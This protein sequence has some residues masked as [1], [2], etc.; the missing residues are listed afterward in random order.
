MKVIP[1]VSVLALLAS[2]LAAQSTITLEDFDLGEDPAPAEEETAA[3]GGGDAAMKQCLSDPGSCE[4][5][6]F[7]S[8]VS[9]SIDDVVNLG[10]VDREEVAPS[11][12]ATDGRT[13]STA[14][15]LPSIDLEVLF[16]SGSH[17]IR[18][19]QVPQL[20]RLSDTLRGSDF[21]RFTLI[22]MG[23]TDAKGSAAYNMKLSQRRAESV[24]SFV[25]A[26]AGVPRARIRSVGLGFTELAR[27]EAPY[28]ERNRRVQLVL[29]PRK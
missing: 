21:T 20:A 12:V 16:D 15:P 27:P 9:F 23:H 10:I 11:E 22:F 14:D 25:A 29:V 24:A 5:N 19:D 7:K 4:D 18:A 8:G 6:E 28:S 17:D 1:I 13:T 26:S 3:R 2:P